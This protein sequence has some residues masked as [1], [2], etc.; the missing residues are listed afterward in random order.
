MPEVSPVQSPDNENED[1]S[2]RTSRTT[3]R[4]IG[5]GPA[6]PDDWSHF[7]INNVLRLLRI[8]NQTQA[9][10][11]L[12]KL[13]IRWWH[14]ST[15]A[16]TRLLERAGVPR[17]VLNLLPGIISTCITCREWARPQPHSVASV[18]LADSFNKQVEAD[19]MFHMIDRCTRWYHS[20]EVSSSEE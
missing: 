15:A 16:M 1:V 2:E 8:G 7:D 6:H 12:R 3:R 14:A 9:R 20:V 18:E 19:L 11:T 10:L 17:E 4:D 5:V 13:H